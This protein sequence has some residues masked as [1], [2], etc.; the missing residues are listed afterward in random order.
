[1]I[2]SQSD[3]NTCNDGKRSSDV[4]LSTIEELERTKKQLEIA[5]ECLKEYARK[6]LWEG[7]EYTPKWDL[8]HACYV[9]GGYSEAEETLQLIEEMNKCM[10]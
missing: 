7:F 2:K 9:D 4:L 3:L 6:D 5:V 8:R 10:K 1:M